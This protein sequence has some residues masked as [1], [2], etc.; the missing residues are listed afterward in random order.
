MR[1]VSVMTNAREII[2][3]SEGPCNRLLDYYLNLENNLA[4]RR[5]S[6]SRSNCEIIPNGCCFGGENQIKRN[7]NLFWFL[8]TLVNETEIGDESN[9]DW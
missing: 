2:L 1:R 7:A 5:L 8:S 6:G 9:A 3:R 4:R